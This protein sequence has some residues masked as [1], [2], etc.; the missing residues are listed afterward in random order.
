[1]K[2]FSCRLAVLVLFLLCGAAQADDLL[3]DIQRQLALEPVIR[4][5]F[6]QTRR[7]AQIKKPLVSR[8]HFLVARDFGVVWAQAAPLP[9]TTRLTR[10]E[11][12]QTDGKET[13]MRLSAD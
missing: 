8:G 9:Q 13:L 12:V 7:L 1:M 2:G 5:E 4:G 10:D 11:I 6:T 3:P